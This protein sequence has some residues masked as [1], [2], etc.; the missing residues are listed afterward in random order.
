M[1]ITQ[2]ILRIVFSK[3]IENNI[4]YKKPELR[5]RFELNRTDIDKLVSAYLL[6]EEDNHYFITI[7]GLLQLDKTIVEDTLSRLNSYLTILKDLYR[8]EPEKPRSLRSLSISGVVLSIIRTDFSF[9]IDLNI[10]SSHNFNSDDPTAFYD[11]TFVISERILDQRNLESV[12]PT[13][14]TPPN[15]NS[16]PHARDRWKKITPLGQG[17]QGTVFLVEDL[18]NSKKHYALK[19]INNSKRAHRF[20]REAKAIK[21][22]DHKN[23]IKIVDYKI[24]DSDSFLVYE[25]CKG[26]S[27]DKLL[28]FSFDETWSIFFDVCSGLMSA[29]NQ[30]VF[31]R[32]IKP[33]N[34]LLRKERSEAVISDF[35]LCYITSEEER[36]TEMFEAV[37]PRIFMAPE[38]EDGKLDNVTKSCD[39]YSLGKLL[40]WLLS[41]GKIFS[42]EKHRE[43]KYDLVKIHQDYRYEHINRLLDHMLKPNAVERLQDVNLVVNQSKI[44]LKLFVGGF[45]PHAPNGL[46]I[47]SYCG[48]GTYNLIADNQEHSASTR[49]FGI[50]PIGTNILKIFGCS[51]C[52]HIQMFRPDLAKGT[53]WT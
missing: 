46:T 2:D 10:F 31:H 23:I 14:T 49:N 27:L 15:N 43:S 32:D 28:P 18:D 6:K 26:S 1:S 37:G 47:C 22:L 12:E 13:K 44:A 41:N 9:L 50:T 21:N 24:A 16:R 48:V 29:H 45:Q 4:G 34:I 17:G 53:M 42:R 40:Y 51:F 30:G 52:G 5:V 7:R 3:Q 39:I 20:D 36:H 11:T 25:L 38:L 33:A 19:K 8:Q 35:G